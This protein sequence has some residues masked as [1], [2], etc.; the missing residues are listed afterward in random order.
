MSRSQPVKIPGPLSE[1]QEERRYKLELKHRASDSY[2]QFGH[3]IEDEE[4]WIVDMNRRLRILDYSALGMAGGNVRRRW[5]QQGIWNNKWKL[6][7]HGK[8]KREK[9]LELES[10]SETDPEGE[11]PP[12]SFLRP[13]T[14]P[15]RQKSDEEKRRIAE[16]RVVQERDREASR[17]YHQFV[18]Q[19][20]KERERIQD[21]SSRVESSAG[22]VS[23]NI[24]TRAYDSVRDTWTRRGIWDDRW[25]LLPGM[26]WRH[27]EPFVFEE[28]TADS[29]EVGKAPEAPVRPMSSA[30][31]PSLFGSTPVTKRRNSGLFTFTKNPAQQ[32]PAADTHGLINERS[33]GADDDQWIGCLVVS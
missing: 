16:R 27:E 15:R 9:P 19:I 13:K 23:A 22:V 28:E 3:Q 21:E 12:Y 11:P 10:E 18:Y 29:H 30:P 2:H 32:G 1:E 5:V 6:F 8:W 14:K 26:A 4:K 17:S 25:G 20:S 31:R 7:P 24:N 33:Q